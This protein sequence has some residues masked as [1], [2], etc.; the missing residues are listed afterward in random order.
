LMPFPTS[1][2]SV[3]ASHKRHAS[4]RRWLI[5]PII[6]SIRPSDAGP[7]ARQIAALRGGQPRHPREARISTCILHAAYKAEL[8][9]RIVVL[10]DVRTRVDMRV[11]QIANSQM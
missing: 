4:G 5:V 7:V 9:W 6:Y 10:A 3:I 8:P 1:L 2:V 11:P